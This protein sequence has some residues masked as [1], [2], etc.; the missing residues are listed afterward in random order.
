MSARFHSLH[1]TKSLNSGSF[2]LKILPLTLKVSFPFLP[3]R[4]SIFT[5]SFSSK[6][7]PFILC[8]SAFISSSY[9]KLPSSTSRTPFPLK[10]SFSSFQG[11]REK[12]ISTF[13]F[14]PVIL[15]FF[16]GTTL[17]HL[18]ISISEIFALPNI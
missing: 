1:S 8:R 7:F 16:M 9:V 14:P 10:S 15:T 17:P 11:K 4:P 13:T 5:L 3:S 12:S 6:I 2:K 18:E